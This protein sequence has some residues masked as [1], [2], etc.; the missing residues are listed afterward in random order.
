MRDVTV[1][2]NYRPEM[3]STKPD[4]PALSLS[5]ASFRSRRS[6]QSECITKTPP[7]HRTTSHATTTL[8][9]R[10]G[11][12]YQRIDRNRL[13][14]SDDGSP[15]LTCTPPSRSPM[16]AVSR[17]TS[18]VFNF[19]TTPRSLAMMM[20]S[21]A[22]NSPKMPAGVVHQYTNVD[23][24][25]PI[26]LDSILGSSSTAT[27]DRSNADSTRVNYT[28]LD[29]VTTGSHH[30]EA[31]PATVKPTRNLRL[32]DPPT[33]YAQI[34]LVAT[35][36]ASQA[37]RMHMRDRQDALDRCCERQTGVGEVK[38]LLRKGSAIAGSLS[39]FGERRLATLEPKR[40][41]SLMSHGTYGRRHS[42]PRQP[43]PPVPSHQQTS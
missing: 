19:D 20:C 23:S 3:F 31:L 9:P 11:K 10:Y 28:D 41:T 13:A 36:A 33:E 34:D 21:S 2:S 15:L 5:N 35:V 43:P 18:S 26:I 39:Q 12:E 38:P 22:D 7:L 29:L 40:T 24:T 1:L 37:S 30:S 17:N 27:I 14:S 6:V 25:P 16:S 8:R 32:H 4:S 42:P